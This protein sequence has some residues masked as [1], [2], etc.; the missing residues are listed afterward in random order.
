MSEKQEIALG[1]QS[2]PSIVANFGLYQDEK[3]QRFIDAKGQ[4]MAKISHRPNLN[5]EFKILDSP[6]VN[7]FAV[8][9]GYVYFTRGIMA[10]FSNEAEFAGVLGHEIG[11]ITARH[12]AKQQSRATMAQLGLIVGLVVSKDF[13]QFADAANQGLQLMFLKFGRDA[14]SQSD[15]LGVQYSTRVGYDS[16]EMANFFKTINRLQEQSGQS[17]PDFLSTH[18]NP[19][20]RY[21]NVNKLSDKWQAKDNTHRNYAVNRDSY[22]QMIDGLIYGEDPRQGYVENGNFYHPELKFQYPIPRNWKTINSPS[23]VQMAPEGG[24]VVLIFT[25]SGQK[26]LQ[27]AAQEI[28]Q[29]YKLQVLESRNKTVNGLPALK[30]ISDQLNEQDPNASLRLQTYLIKYNDLIYVFHGVALKAKFNSYQSLFTNTME[31]FKKLTERNKLDVL[32]ERVFVK[33]ATRTS[34]LSNVLKDFNQPTTRF[35]ELAI[36]NGMELNEQVQ[37]GTLIKIID[38]KKGTS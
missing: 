18:P 33:A 24:E 32:P 35:Q 30:L 19:V 8:P 26:D 36:L 15:K 13:R 10:H 11:H 28:T 29:N 25:L 2:D 17:I 22:L 20:D 16:H 9:G 7:A 3:L 5:Y 31:G 1:K 38:K 21:E 37:A 12:S 6:V 34:T 27:A 14:E 4:E 23:Q